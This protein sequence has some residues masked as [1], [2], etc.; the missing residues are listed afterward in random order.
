MSVEQKRTLQTVVDRRRIKEPLIMLKKKEKVLM[1]PKLRLRKPLLTD[2]T[3]CTEITYPPW[4]NVRSC[5]FSVNDPSNADLALFDFDSTLIKFNPSSSRSSPSSSRSSGNDLLFP[6]IPD[7]LKQIKGRIVVLSNQYGIATNNTTHAEVQRQMYEFRLQVNVSIDFYYA[8]EKDSYR[9]PMTDMIDLMRE[10]GISGRILF[11]CGD[12]AG[13]KGDH[14]NTDFLF[15]HNLKIPFYTPENLFN[16]VPN[17]VQPAVTEKS[18]TVGILEKTIFA[19]VFEDPVPK[20]VVMIGP[21]GSG[22]SLNSRLFVDKDFVY[23]NRDTQNKRMLSILQNAIHARQNI[24]TDNTH[25]SIESRIPYL[26]AKK[27]GYRVYAVFWNLKKPMSFHLNHLRAQILHQTIKVP[28][29][30]IHSY[31]KHLIPPTLEEGF[32]RIFEF[33]RFMIPTELNTEDFRRYYNY[34]FI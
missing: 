17:F 18:D 3:D 12:A 24:V 15:A 7:F 16:S 10:H 22:K 32:E 28:T 14:S 4:H 31:Y 2:V 21:Q 23:V 13:R 9:K 20:I 6:N 30:A 29:V 34:M 11:Y 25:P 33:D 8:T 19:E 1:P 26:D 27:H 5:Y